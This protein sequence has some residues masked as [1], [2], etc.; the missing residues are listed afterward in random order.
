[1]EFMVFFRQ[2][3]L[4]FENEAF[5]GPEIMG[6]YSAVSCKGYALEPELAFPAANS[7]VHRGGS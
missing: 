7:N 3:M 4:V 6:R 2:L 5:D 1:M